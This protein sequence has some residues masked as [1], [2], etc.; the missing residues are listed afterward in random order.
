MCRGLP[1]ISIQLWWIW[2]LWIK[3]ARQKR[4]KIKMIK[5]VFLYSQMWK[6]TN[7]WTPILKN[8]GLSIKTLSRMWKQQAH[9]S[10]YVELVC[11]LLL[12][13]MKFLFH[14]MGNILHI[15]IINFR[16]CFKL[17]KT[18]EEKLKWNF[19]IRTLSQQYLKLTL[20]SYINL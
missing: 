7:H 4:N 14:Q 12:S 20:S 11:L 15:L 9:M 2:H 13:W 6:T 18:I 19:F 16:K 3:Q 8:L 1:K 5:V 17:K 10:L